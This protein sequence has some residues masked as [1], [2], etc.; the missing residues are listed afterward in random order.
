MKIHMY[1]ECIFILKRF[2]AYITS[3]GCK[4]EIQ[5]QYS[6][7]TNLMALRCMSSLAY[8]SRG[9]SRVGRECGCSVSSLFLKM[10]VCV[11]MSVYYLCS[12]RLTTTVVFHNHLDLH[13]FKYC[14][15]VVPVVF[16]EQY[17]CLASSYQMGTRWHSWLR[18]CATS[19]KVAGLIPDGVIGIFH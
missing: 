3:K 13:Q 10:H 9:G 15:S 5:I 1:S 8:E 19:R 11:L 14:H 7:I 17:F 4:K 2:L 18:H 12:W 6:K 16:E